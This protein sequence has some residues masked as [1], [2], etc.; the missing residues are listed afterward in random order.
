MKYAFALTVFVVTLG[1]SGCRASSPQAKVRSSNQEAEVVAIGL[2]HFLHGRTLTADS[3]YI[4]VDRIDW[5]VVLERAKL[6]QPRI[7][8]K[9]G[10]GYEVRGKALIDKETGMPCYAVSVELLKFSATTAMIRIDFVS[11]N[12]GMEEEFQKLRKAGNQW[13]VV[14]VVQGDIP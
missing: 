14:E 8:F 11:R 4:D 6:E 12:L 7:G 2:A 10:R 1:S 9:S 13:T 5:H 3:I